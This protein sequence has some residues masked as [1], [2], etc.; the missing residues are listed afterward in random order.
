M[1]E[2]FDN[3]EEELNEEELENLRMENEIKKIKLSLEHGADFSKFPDAEMPPEIEGQFLDYIQQFEEQFANRK[4]IL[5]YDMA[6][7][8]AWKPVAEIPDEEIS[9]ELNRLMSVLHENAIS[10]DTIC[11]VEERELYRFIT[12]ELF[13][14]ETDDIQ[15]PGMT[16]GFI[17]EEFHPNHEYDIKNRC[18]ELV[19]N[20][21]DKEKELQSDFSG[22]AK[23]VEGRGKEKKNVHTRE[24]VVEKISHFRD[25]F[26]SFTIHEF[27]L[28]SIAV[29]E[30]K[31]DAI[32]TWD[33]SF[34]GTIDGSNETIELEGFCFF[35]LKREYDWWVIYKMDM[36]GV[37]L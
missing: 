18:T 11:D 1:Q 28:A 9:A 14:H 5:V 31:N 2:P 26:S 12:E 16:H 37:V 27:T 7:R 10:V 32:A 30:A 3:N 20:I 35:S 17:Y 25:S 33:I 22:L 36:P 8:P 23:D 34:S 15:I 29:N 21:L 19:H 4:S 13:N 6:G 24:E